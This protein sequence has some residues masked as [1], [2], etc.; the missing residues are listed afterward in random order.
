[1]EK[2]SRKNLLMHTIDNLSKLPI[3]SQKTNQDIRDKAER[4]SK[5]YSFSYEKNYSLPKEELHQVFVNLKTHYHENNRVTE[6]YFLRKRNIKR[7]ILALNVAFENEK[8]SIIDSEYFTLALKL[9]FY[10]ERFKKSYIPLLER[11]I[12][13]SWDKHRTLEIVDNL[14]AIVRD[15]Q[16][17]DYIDSFPSLKYLISKD[18]FTLL[19]TDLVEKNIRISLDSGVS[20]N[21]LFFLQQGTYFGDSPFFYQ[22][23]NFLVIYMV[24][25]GNLL[26]KFSDIESTLKT[27]M[28]ISLSKKSIPIMIQYIHKQPQGNYKERL[29]NLAYELIGNP[30]IDAYWMDI[31]G[32]EESEIKLLKKSQL[33]LNNW[34]ANKFLTAFFNN[35]SANTDDDR[36]EYW[37]KYV[38]SIVD[39][40]I[41]A[42][43]NKY[44]NV[45]NLMSS[46]PEEYIRLKVGRVV[47]CSKYIFILKF[48]NKTIIEFSTK[49]N[50]ALVYDNDDFLC[51]K[52]ND[53]EFNYND[54]KMSNYENLIFQRLGSRVF[55]LN[56]TGRLFHNE[57]WEP[58]MDYW[59]EQYLE[60]D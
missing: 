55:N 30:G 27:I 57:G 8:L 35:L 28:N 6:V 19:L 45:L 10:Q 16:N 12:F 20:R 32:G 56:R 31:D 9:I 53:S 42:D 54:F 25:K 48:K 51:P 38:D 3:I 40:K 44:N 4:I 1:M 50:S 47:N 13:E 5:L 22:F 23:F 58:F 15:S 34:L 18:C 37:L 60:L 14:A 24:R 33:I 41:L 7:L 39:Y 49:G 52:L 11:V 21:I 43:K 17:N 29:I 36:R 46:I 59:I 26:D 2:F